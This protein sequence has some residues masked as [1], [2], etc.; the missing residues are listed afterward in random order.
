MRFLAAPLLLVLAACGGD[1][2]GAPGDAAAPADSATPA[3]SASPAADSAV[4]CATSAVRTTMDVRY[5]ETPGVPA[6]LQSLDLYQP[7]RGAGCPATPIVVWVHGGGWSVGD[8]RNQLTDKVPFFTS[9][10][11]L[12]VSVNYRLSP[13][14]P[15]SLAELEPGRI[16]YPIHDE[17]V[18]AAVAW[19]REHAAEHGGDPTRVTLMGHSAGAGIVSQVATNP[20]F[21]AA[22]GL[23][24]GE[25]RCAVP[26]DTEAYDVAESASGT[27]TQAVLY[28]N[29]FGSDPA[30]WAEAS[31]MS[32]VAAGLPAFFVVTRGS[33][34]RV[35]M[36]RAFV[37]A[38]ESAGVRAQ[39]LLATGYDHE[40][41]NDAIGSPADTVI[42][43][44]LEAFLADCR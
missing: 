17:D 28:Q 38:L 23:S 33:A 44:V 12:F 9:R 35:A 18:A 7:E 24:V 40:G 22:H 29:A 15:A 42:T 14:P 2:D 27:G 8:K 34:P 5:L 6:N 39:L 36:S 43:P 26:L 11:W 37:A 10:G 20:R 25:L 4:A 13:R 1:D 32:H 41:V 16:T 31:A 3:D 21:L 30:V 19:V